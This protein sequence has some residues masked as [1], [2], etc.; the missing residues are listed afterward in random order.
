MNKLFLLPVIAL[1][2][3]MAVSMA[4]AGC[5]LTQVSPNVCSSNNSG[6]LPGTWDDGYICTGGTTCIIPE[7]TSAGIGLAMSGAGIG[8]A[9]LRR[10]LKN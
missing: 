5:C 8:F 6:C 9:L 1:V 4:S 7:F 3:V 10:K 2:A